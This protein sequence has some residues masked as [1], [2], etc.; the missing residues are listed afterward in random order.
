M[1]RNLAL[2]AIGLVLGMIA[3]KHVSP[4]AAAQEPRSI[5]FGPADAI[6]V[7]G[8]LT[9]W[10]ECPVWRY[11]AD[12]MVLCAAP[13]ERDADMT[14]MIKDL[15]HDK[16]DLDLCEIDV[17]LVRAQRQCAFTEYGLDNEA[18]AWLITPLAFRWM[19]QGNLR[20]ADRL[21]RESYEIFDRDDFESIG[22]GHVLRGWA[23]LKLELGETERAKEFADLQLL[24]ERDEYDDE[25]PSPMGVV[26]ALEF[27]AHVLER[28]GRV[29]KARAARDEAERLSALPPQCEDGCWRDAKRRRRMGF[30]LEPNW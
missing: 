12:T 3:L 15:L 19:K 22:L 20:R 14:Q 5:Q 27:Q 25:M 29:E 26:S 23:L 4:D 7:P 16:A 24:L 28:I 17:A 1:R 2:L 21:F 9:Y 11:R 18:Y 8:G 6:V 13:G 10:P 30:M